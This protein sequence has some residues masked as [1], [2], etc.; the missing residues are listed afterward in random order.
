MKH[1]G[2]RL[3]ERYSE[4]LTENSGRILLTLLVV[5]GILM[6]QASKV[7][8]VEQQT[9]DFLPDSEPVIRSF[10]ILD[11]EFPSAG[12]TTY[13]ILIETEP[14][15]ANSSELRDVR[16]PKFLR[17]VETVTDE[18]RSFDKV[19]SVDSPAG[20]FNDIPSSKNGVIQ[21][22]KRMGEG[23]WSGSISRDYQAVRI[24]ATSRGLSKQEQ[25]ELAGLIEKAVES[26]PESGDY[27]ISYSGQVYIDR[28][29]QSQAQNTM[30]TTSRLSMVGVLIVVIL[31]F[32]SIYY[33]FN[34]LLTVFFG[35]A[36]GFGL[37]GILG[38]NITPQT[39]GTIS[40]GIGIAV[41][42]GIQPIARYRE[43]R[44]KENIQEALKQTLQ[45]VATPMTVG[46]AAAN[47]GFLALAVGKLTFLKDLG[48]LLTLT[49]TVAY[50]SAFTVLPAS[51]V[52]YDKHLTQKTTALKQKIHTKV[53]T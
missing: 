33:G 42:F 43:E 21:A 45:G 35:I 53:K 6:A 18:I 9:E 20:L 34:S 23:R 27:D 5:S 32:R 47:I 31:V 50:I 12:G 15:N 41:D 48:I 22:M 39:S 40:L 19:A 16:S 2:N 37:Y 46:L 13:T 29:F 7:E 44:K 51:I 36:V 49:T 26:H 30:Q 4:I 8:T 28:A 25:N 3:M 14:D 11:A 24:Q 52:F 1:Y 10:N 38:M 17:Y